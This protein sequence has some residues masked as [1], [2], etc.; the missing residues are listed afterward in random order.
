MAEEVAGRSRAEEQLEEFQEEVEEEGDETSS[1][2]T[3]ALGLE[4][5]ILKIVKGQALVI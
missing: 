1:R 5:V 4:Y 2:G 3:H